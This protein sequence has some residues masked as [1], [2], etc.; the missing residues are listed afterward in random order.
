M[1]AFIAFL[2]FVATVC[3]IQRSSKKLK[4]IVIVLFGICGFASATYALQQSTITRKV[5]EFQ[6]AFYAGNTLSCY[7]TGSIVNVHKQNFI[8]IPNQRVFLGKDSVGG[9][10]VGILECSSYKHLSNQEIIID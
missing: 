7:H 8:Y 1:S 9:I 6:Q 4:I 2:L 5:Q 10:S 3:K